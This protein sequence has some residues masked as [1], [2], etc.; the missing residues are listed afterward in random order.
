MNEAAQLANELNNPARKNYA[1]RKTITLGID[2]LW[3]ADLVEMHELASSL[4]F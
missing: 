4:D 1:R 3:Q 2:D